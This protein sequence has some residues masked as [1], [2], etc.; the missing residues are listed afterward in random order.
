M[1]RKDMFE[2]VF[3]GVDRLVQ[4]ALPKGIYLLAGPPGA[5]KTYFAYNSWSMV[6]E[7][8]LQAESWRT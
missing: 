6:S 4:A 2:E 5:G 3:P 1:Y 7:G 8:R